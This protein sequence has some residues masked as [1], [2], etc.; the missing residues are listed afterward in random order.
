[1]AETIRDIHADF[2]DI[3]SNMADIQYVEEGA[4]ADDTTPEVVPFGADLLHDVPHALGSLSANETRFSVNEEE[5]K[6]GGIPRPRPGS[7]GG[8]GGSGNGAGGR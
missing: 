6:T 3:V 1:M 5:K 8:N 4:I 2:D 7:G